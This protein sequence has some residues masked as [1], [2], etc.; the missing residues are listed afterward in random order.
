MFDLWAQHT[1]LGDVPTAGGGLID[2]VLTLYEQGHA[3]GKAGAFVGAGELYRWGQV[4]GIYDFSGA[5][6]LFSQALEQGEDGDCGRGDRA[7]AHFNLAW[8][9]FNG[10]GTEQNLNVARQHF[11][12]AARL[13]N[14]AAAEALA[15]IY[16][17]GLGV[18]RDPVLAHEFASKAFLWNNLE[19]QTFLALTL[20]HDQ[21]LDLPGL[22]ADGSQDLRLAPRADALRFMGDAARDER[23]QG[24]LYLAL[25]ALD[26]PTV[27][28]QNGLGGEPE[29]LLATLGGAMG[30]FERCYAA[31]GASRTS[32]F[33]RMR[34]ELADIDNLA[35]TPARY[36]AA[37]G[38][39]HDP[40]RALAFYQAMARTNPAAERLLALDRAPYLTANGEVLMGPG[41]HTLADIVALDLGDEMNPLPFHLLLSP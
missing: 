1:Y 28:S 40:K 18:P 30:D 39:P 10:Q 19:N 15:E 4:G 36:D 13:G 24:T 38:W 14:F 33:D 29:E 25:A 7:A 9:T 5:H 34:A 3:A 12:E 23:F 31:S 20:F 27:L 17:F 37:G 41:P 22:S 26:D 32:H 16:A 2:E 11:L 35:F 21:G 8:L 6:N